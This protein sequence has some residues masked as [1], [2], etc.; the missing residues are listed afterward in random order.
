MHVYSYMYMCMFDYIVYILCR[1]MLISDR[2][3]LEG[4][5]QG[6]MIVISTLPHITIHLYNFVVHITQLLP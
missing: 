4:Q 5:G 1:L 2:V 3:V 6:K